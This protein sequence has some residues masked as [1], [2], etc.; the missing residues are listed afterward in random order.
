MKVFRNI[1]LQTKKSKE[2]LPPLPC[3]NPRAS[4]A[5][6]ASHLKRRLEIL[7]QAVVLLYGCP[8][9]PRYL[10]QLKTPL[11]INIML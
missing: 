11:Q 1:V 5:H 7:Q 8:T 3:Y 6:H 4:L 2:S 10:L 9:A